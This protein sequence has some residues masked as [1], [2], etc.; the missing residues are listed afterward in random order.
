MKLDQARRR[1]LQHLPG[2]GGL[3]LGGDR[4]DIEMPDRQRHGRPE[5]RRNSQGQRP[6]GTGPVVDQHMCGRKRVDLGQRKLGAA[7]QQRVGTRHLRFKHQISPR[8]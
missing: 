6:C 8:A 7:R 4:R 1:L 2:S 5:P 3:G